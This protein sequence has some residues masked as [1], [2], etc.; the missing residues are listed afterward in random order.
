M[1]RN[2]VYCAG[3]LAAHAPAHVAPHLPRLLH[4]LT[5][6]LTLVEGE[7]RA[8]VDNAVSVCMYKDSTADITC[9]RILLTVI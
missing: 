6:H 2:A 7:N 8:I 4:A 1:R 9:V 3:V 5:P